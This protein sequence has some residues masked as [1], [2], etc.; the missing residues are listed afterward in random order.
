MKLLSSLLVVGGILLLGV[1]FLWPAVDNGSSTWTDDKAAEYQEVS[2]RL[3]G[4]SFR[5]L[6]KAENKKLFDEAESQYRALDDQ[7]QNART[8]GSRTAFWLKIVGGVLAAV[9]GVGYLLQRDAN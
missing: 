6:N 9:G 3:H 2:A 7:L 1:S 5:D 4:L 8:R